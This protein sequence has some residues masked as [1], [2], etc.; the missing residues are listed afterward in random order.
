[1]EVVGPPQRWVMHADWKLASEN[2]IGDGYH[3]QSTHMSTIKAGIMRV[4]SPAYLKDGGSSPGRTG[5]CLCGQPVGRLQLPSEY[6]GLH[7]G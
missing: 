1:M 4:K 7:E 6:R 5:A 2:F 3:T